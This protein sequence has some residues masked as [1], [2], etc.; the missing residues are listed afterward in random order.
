MIVLLILSLNSCN[1]NQ[2]H[3]FVIH[4]NKILK[5]FFNFMFCHNSL[6]EVPEN[7]VIFS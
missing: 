7:D 1:G 6:F 3:Y 2:M 5:P 4:C